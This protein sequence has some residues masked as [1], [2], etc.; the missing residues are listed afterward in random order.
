[1]Y[2]V[3]EDIDNI[4]QLICLHTATNDNLKYDDTNNNNAVTNVK[5]G[6]TML[7]HTEGNPIADYWGQTTQTEFDAF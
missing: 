1:M 6:D 4:F 5:K 2:L 7:P 3:K